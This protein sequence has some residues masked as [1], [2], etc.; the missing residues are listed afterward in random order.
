MQSTANTS[1]R[2]KRKPLRKARGRPYV[3]QDRLAEVYVRDMAICQICGGWVNWNLRHQFF[4]PDR[5]TI[6]H[7]Q[8]KSKGGAKY[9]ISNQQLAHLHCNQEKGVK[10]MRQVRAAQASQRLRLA[11]K[12]ARAPAITETELSRLLRGVPTERPRF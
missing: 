2:V 4:H 3:H 10:T 1:L 5:P 7:R 8:A 11:A 6:D 9:A 12:V